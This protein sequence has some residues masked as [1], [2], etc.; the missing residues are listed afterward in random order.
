MFG[1]RGDRDQPEAAVERPVQEASSATPARQQIRRRASTAGPPNPSSCTT[2]RASVFHLVGRFGAITFIA[3]LSTIA[4]IRLLGSRDYGQYAA[5]V[6]TWSVLGATADFGFSLMLSRDMPH[7]TARTA[8]RCAPPM[9]SR[10]PGPRLLALVMVVL[11]FASGADTTR[12]L[13]LL[14]LAPSMVFNGL[15]PARVFFLLRHRTGLLLRLDVITTFLQVSATVL[16]AALGLGVAA[17]AAA[18]STGAILNSVVVAVAAHRLLEPSTELRVGRLG[19]VRRS[20]PLGMLAIMTKVYLMI[21][22]VLLGWLITGSRLGDYAAASK[23]LTVLATIAGVVTAGALPAISSL[24]GRRGEL[25]TLIGRIWTWLVVGVVPIF[26]GVALFAPTLIAVL[27]GHSYAGA[28]PLLRILCLAGA[29]SVVNNLLGNVMIAYRK[30]R[31][32]FLQNAAA[33]VV[34][35]VGNLILVPKVGVVASAWLTSG[36]EVLVLVAEVAVIGREVDLWPCLAK[37]ARPAVAVVVAAA[38]AVVLSR[39]TV[40]AIAVSGF[41]FV[42]MVA[43]LRAWPP[44]F[45]PAAIVA[46]LRRAD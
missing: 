9:R 36:C 26:V 41:T 43:G 40:L 2:S 7:T 3:G 32:L 27:L 20:L 29:V 31:A 25:E 37:S 28:A 44:D 4:I 11:A 24:V 19:L 15:N 35:V 13:A 33:I 5:A 30:T 38:I 23:L 46:D 10:S 14:V 12:G 22:L 21:D 17:I 34:N 42:A 16:A 45:R 18:L 39:W 1:S 8:R 6:A